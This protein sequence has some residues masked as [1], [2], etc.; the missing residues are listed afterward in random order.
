[1]SQH[2]ELAVR[3]TALSDI[4]LRDPLSQKILCLHVINGCQILKLICRTQIDWLR[5]WIKSYKLIFL[6]S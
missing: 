1:M 5:P 4:E 6:V 3:S 2:S